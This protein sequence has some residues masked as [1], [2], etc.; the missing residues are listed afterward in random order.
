MFSLESPQRGDSNEFTQYTISQ[1]KKV[2]HP[3]LS[4]ICNY[5][6]C[7]KGPKNEF[8]TAMVNEPSVSKPPKFYC[9]FKK[10]CYT[11][12]ESNCGTFIFTSLMGVNSRSQSFLIRVDPILERFCHLGKQTGS[13]KS[14]VSFETLAENHGDLTMHLKFTRL[15]NSLS[16]CCDCTTSLETASNST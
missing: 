11:Y 1:Y 4:Q 8:E 16:D 10:S 9:M 14:F 7:S 3:K 6:I 2:N 13:H 5:R 15:V 12:R